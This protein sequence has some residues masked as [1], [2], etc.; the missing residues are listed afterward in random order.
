MTE[1]LSGRLEIFLE[2]EQQISSVELTAIDWWTYCVGRTKCIGMLTPYKLTHR[3]PEKSLNLG[4]KSLT[5]VASSKAQG[6]GEDQ[7]NWITNPFTTLCRGIYQ[8]SLE[9]MYVFDLNYFFSRHQD[10][11]RGSPL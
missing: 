9:T 3:I 6:E 10:N 8:I 5:C 2:M 4:R 7:M 1:G 11:G